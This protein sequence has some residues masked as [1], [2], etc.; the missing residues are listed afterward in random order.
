MVKKLI[1]MANC[2]KQEAPSIEDEFGAEGEY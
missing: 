1:Y 2:F